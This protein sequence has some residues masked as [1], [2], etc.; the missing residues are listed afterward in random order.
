MINLSSSC[1][2]MHLASDWFKNRH[3]TQSWP[4]KMEGTAGKCF[5]TPNRD[6]QAEAYSLPP[7]DLDSAW[8]YHDHLVADP[9][10]NRG[11]SGK[12]LGS[13]WHYRATGSSVPVAYPPLDFQ[14]L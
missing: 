12:F 8:T 7:L 14:W 3:V 6:T 2:P 11:A 4:M 1:Y 10:E 13:L 9:K 5:P